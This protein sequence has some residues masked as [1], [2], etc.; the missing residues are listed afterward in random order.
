LEPNAD[1]LDIRSAILGDGIVLNRTS[2][3]G[4]VLHSVAGGTAHELGFF[5]EAKDAWKALDAIDT[6]VLDAPRLA[7]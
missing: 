7:A 1:T 4:M 5:T 3:G 2:G 6:A